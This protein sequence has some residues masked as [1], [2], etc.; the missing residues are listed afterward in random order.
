MGRG[1]DSPGTNRAVCWNWAFLVKQE[2][3][4]SSGSGFPPFAVDI[5]RTKDKDTISAFK[6]KGKMGKQNKTQDDTGWCN[7]G[8]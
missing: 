2:C 7:T 1:R 6:S 4:K 3:H 8:F 5:V